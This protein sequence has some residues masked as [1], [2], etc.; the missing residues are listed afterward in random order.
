MDKKLTCICIVLKSKIF[1][2]LL[3]FKMW[4]NILKNFIIMSYKELLIND[5][6]YIEILTSF[7]YL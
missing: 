2:N 5:N 7:A 1:A 3:F 4:C 6:S